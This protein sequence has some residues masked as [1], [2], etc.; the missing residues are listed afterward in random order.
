MTISLNQFSFSDYDEDMATTEEVTSN[1]HTYPVR[2][3]VVIFHDGNLTDIVI[4]DRQD[5]LLTEYWTGF[6]NN[7]NAALGTSYEIQV[8]P[9]YYGSVFVGIGGGDRQAIADLITDQICY[10]E[11]NVCYH[12][13]MPNAYEDFIMAHFN[14]NEPDDI[15][16]NM[17][18]DDKVAFVQGWEEQLG[19][20]PRSGSEI[21]EDYGWT[22]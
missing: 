17:T 10:G 18:T 21:C 16:E 8:I 9:N 14:L 20:E 3:G 1:N 5:E 4:H 15:T 6:I 7:A 19:Y 13:W 12:K 11:E 22:K 2:D